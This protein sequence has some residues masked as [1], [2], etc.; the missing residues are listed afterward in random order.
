[1]RP[2]W[3]HQHVLLTFPDMKDMTKT[4]WPMLIGGVG[5]SVIAAA[6]ALGVTGNRR[7]QPALPLPLAPLATLGKLHPA[8]ATGQ[9]GPEG[10]PLTRGRV[11]PARGTVTA[12]LD[13]RV[14][15]G[16]PRAIPL[17]AHSQVE[18]EVGRPLVAPDHVSFPS[19]L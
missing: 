4:R 5:L 8:P 10:V 6:V 15:T 12:L 16:D 1:M 9:P 14:F 18:L 13:G 2:A 11:G 17:L 19:G 7:A 3:R